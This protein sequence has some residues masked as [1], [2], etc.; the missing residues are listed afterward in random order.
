[1]SSRWGILALLFTVR[2]ALGFQFQAVGSVGDSLKTDLGLS[3]TELGTLI[4][5]FFL[6]GLALAIPAGYVGRHMTDRL[7]VTLGMTT[8]ALGG[9]ACALAQDFFFMAAGRV[10]SGI[11]FVVV[12]IY[13]AKMVADWFAGKEIATAMAVLVMSWPFGI[14]MGQIGQSWVATLF[15]WR[16]TFVIAAVY[17]LIG[18]G[19]VFALYRPPPAVTGGPPVAA[20]LTRREWMLILIASAT[21]AFFNGAYV[22][23]LSF[24]PRVL[25]QG[26]FGPLE[27]AAVI[28]LASW[29]MIVSGAICGQIADRS[30]KSDIILYGCL[31]IAMIVLALLPHAGLAVPLS[32]AFG[33]IGMAPAGLIMALTGQA[34]AP[35]RRAFGM[36]VFFSGYFLVTTPAPAIAGWLYDLS[37]DPFQ[38]ILFAIALFGATILAYTAFR[39]AQGRRPA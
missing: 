27:A 19:L 31:A 37:G 26:G 15:G 34:M 24:A 36:G 18:A 12:A 28:S 4:G 30:G 3:Y 33:L 14:A 9:I 38:P 13:M 1:M 32:L 2:T 11:G 35:Q 23:Y 22:V 25:V 5:V 6:P 21:W 16:P 10:L 7:L 20:A 29:V 39:V 8:L 17:C